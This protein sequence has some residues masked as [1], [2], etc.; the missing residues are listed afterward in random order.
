MADRIFYPVQALN[1]HLKIIAGSFEPAGTG[2]PI[3]VKGQ[4][5]A[6][7]REAQG[8]FVVTLTDRYNSL[9]SAT[10]TPQLGD[11]VDDVICVIG[12][13]DVSSAKTVVIWV[14]GATDTFSA[15][16]YESSTVRINFCFMLANASYSI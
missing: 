15:I 11:A 1:P 4:G 14:G 7:T 13:A 12:L 5:F 3:N 16:D 8:K 9:L 6:I 2:V 10:A